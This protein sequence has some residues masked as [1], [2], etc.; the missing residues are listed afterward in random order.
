[1]AVDILMP[2]LGQAMVTGLIIAWHVADG[3]EV[4]AGAPLLTIE[5][6][7]SAFEIEAA[8]TGVVHHRM[9]A[10]TEADVGTILGT[11]TVVV[12]GTHPSPLPYDAPVNPAASM[13]RPAPHVNVPDA[14]AASPRARQLAA[15][16]KIPLKNI[17]ASR[18]DGMIT[19]SDVERAVAARAGT[20]GQ[21]SLPSTR[22]P[23]SAGHKSAIRRLQTS[24]Q[25]AP[26]IVQ[27]IEIDATALSAAQEAI[28][29]GELDASLNDVF[30]QAAAD[31]MAEFRDLN[32][33]IENDTIVENE[34]ISVGIAV[35]TGRG[36]RT[37][38]IDAANGRSLKDIASL[39]RAAIEAARQGR[40]IAGRASLTVSNLGRYG[41]RCGTPVLNLDESV[42]V[43]VGE[44]VNKPVVADGAI[45][46]KPRLTLS[47]AYD[48]RIADGLRAA[49]FS[50]A[51]RR[52]LE[53]IVPSTDPGPRI[54]QPSRAVQMSS[55]AGM[56]C[57]L[58]DGGHDWTAE[59]PPTIDSRIGSDTGIDPVAL[60]L[61]GLLS[62]VTIG[63]RRE[64]ENRKLVIGRLIGSIET[65]SQGEV[66]SIRA[67]I[68]VWSPALPDEIRAMLEPAKAASF[69]YGM[70]SP[71]LD[72]AID[73]SVHTTQ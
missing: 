14:P 35:A 38:L 52:R 10:G 72:V 61:S 22:R 64:A 5:S 30:I 21:L 17:V 31:T 66:K 46:A 15:A 60:V 12:V 73:L 65:Q 68:E 16:E 8:A 11:I 56:R 42:L 9:A 34:R 69:V 13:E 18:A 57:D 6:D 25:Q 36:L 58:T 2:Q 43:F 4:R 23:V 28:R 33:Y 70:L 3:A 49:E 44:I 32:A 40:A 20:N 62:S 24:W 37:P 53:C 41:V 50:A 54:R 55:S 63:I 45:V 1:M 27:M 19:A 29:K 39:S 47:I 71:H 67:R 7:K 26:H 48:H 59:E 51:M